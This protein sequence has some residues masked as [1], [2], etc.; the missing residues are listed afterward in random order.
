MRMRNHISKHHRSRGSLRLA[1]AMMLLMAGVAQ[2]QESLSPTANADSSANRGAVNQDAVNQGAVLDSVLAV[3]NNQVILASD[4][5]F[6]MR[7]FRLLPIGG[8]GDYTPSKAIERLTTRALIEQQ[9][10]QEDPQGLE[11]TTKDL[12][13]SLAEL[14]QNLPGCKRGDGI[15]CA[16]DAGWRAYLATLGLTPVRV[17]DYWRH[18]MA[19]LRFIELRFRSGIR[20]MPEDIQTYYRDTLVPKY[21][22]PEDAPKLDRISQRIQEILLQQKVNVLLSDWLKSLQ[23]QGQVEILDPLLRAQVGSAPGGEGPGVSE[24]GSKAP[25]A[26]GSPIPAVPPPATSAPVPPFGVPPQIGGRLEP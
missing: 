21:P 1:I 24:P 8:R 26:V 17:S 16:T 7:I 25:D 18:R 20:I 15:N 13:E 6:E 3:V 5:D 4:L 12:E 10:L 14:K 2:S 11:V 9:I 22:S 23:D 19:V